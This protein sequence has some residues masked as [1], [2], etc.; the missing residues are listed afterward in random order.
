MTNGD[1][2]G[3]IDP[4][5]LAREEAGCILNINYHVGNVDNVGSQS[6]SC[7]T[8]KIIDIAS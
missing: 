7:I 5:D 2:I 3:G 4:E 8:L 1:Y 6:Y